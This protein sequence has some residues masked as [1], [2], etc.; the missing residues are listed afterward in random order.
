MKQDAPPRYPGDTSIYSPALPDANGNYPLGRRLQGSALNKADDPDQVAMYTFIPGSASTEQLGSLEKE[1]MAHSDHAQLHP[2][3]IAHNV[4]G[5]LQK[6]QGNNYWIRGDYQDLNKLADSIGPKIEGQFGKDKSYITMMTNVTPGGTVISKGTPLEHMRVVV[7]FAAGTPKNTV[8]EPSLTPET[9]DKILNVMSGDEGRMVWQHADFNGM[10][11]ATSTTKDVVDKL[12][13][14][15]RGL[16]A[17][18][19]VDEKSEHGG[20][21]RTIVHHGDLGNTGA[22]KFVPTEINLE[23]YP[24]KGYKG[25]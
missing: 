3:E 17:S 23:R 13:P 14:I 7:P 24:V 18:E 15:V 6:V 20:P 11:L 10:H 25:E 22:T 21:P 12:F 19:D 2:G 1:I 8:G 16:G 4:N 9:R 5:Q